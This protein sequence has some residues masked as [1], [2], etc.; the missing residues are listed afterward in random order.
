MRSLLVGLAAVL[1]GSAS[2]PPQRPVTPP[3]QPV[4]GE[5]QKAIAERA[6]A[7]VAVYQFEFGGRRYT[8][9]NSSDAQQRDRYSELVFIDGQLVCARERSMAT[10]SD[11]DSEL[12]QWELVGEPDGLG[13]L[14]ERLREAC[15]LVAAVPPVVSSQVVEVPGPSKN[16]EGG[17]SEQPAGSRPYGELAAALVGHYG[18]FALGL[19]DPTQLIFAPLIM[20]AVGISD[21]NEA[22]AARAAEERAAMWRAATTT[23]EVVQLLGKPMVEFS[24]PNVETRVMA[25][26]LDDVHRYY[27]GLSGDKTVWFHREYP[28]LHDLAEQAIARQR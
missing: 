14:A 25:F 5:E 9:G 10:L 24:L 11:L 19:R 7:F 27:V 16:A 21:A 13:R 8:L 6:F 3:L 18:S 2:E 23:E 26:Q 4:A 15:R 22:K 28:W 20:L 17:S 12:T 1:V